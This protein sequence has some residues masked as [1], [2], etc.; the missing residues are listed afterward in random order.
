MLLSMATCF[1][2]T[3]IFGTHVLTYYAHEDLS[4][5]TMSPVTLQY[6]NNFVHF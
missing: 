5:S 6:W 2:G 4:P 3:I 1:C